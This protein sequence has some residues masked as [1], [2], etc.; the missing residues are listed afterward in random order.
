MSYENETFRKAA[1]D[2]KISGKDW[3]GNEAIEDFSEH[4]HNNYDKWER[5]KHGYEGIKPIADT[6]WA[7]NKHRYSS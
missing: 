5:E 1:R 3:K 7:N 2:A 6:W 4:Y